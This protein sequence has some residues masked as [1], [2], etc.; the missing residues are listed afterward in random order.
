MTHNRRRIRPTERKESNWP[1]VV[2]GL[3]LLQ[4][5]YLG[6][7]FP[8]ML[9]SSLSDQT[10]VEWEDHLLTSASMV[11]I[12]L[13][14]VLAWGLLR[15]RRWARLGGIVLML[16]I[17]AGLAITGWMLALDSRGAGRFAKLGVGMA[18]L[19]AVVGIYCGVLAFGLWRAGDESDR[20]SRRAS[21]KN[22]QTVRS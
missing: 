8:G 7:L 20:R 22:R 17:G 10:S 5:L 6:I 9:R 16:L 12:V 2:A 13:F 18:G 14:G 21:S 19:L 3:F 15:R 11:L 4:A 1:P